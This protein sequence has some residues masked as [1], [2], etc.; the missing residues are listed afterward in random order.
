MFLLTTSDSIPKRRETRVSVPRKFGLWMV[1]PICV[2][3]FWWWMVAPSRVNPFGATTFTQ[4][5][6]SNPIRSLTQERWLGQKGVRLRSG[7]RQQLFSIFVFC[8]VGGRLTA[9][10]ASTP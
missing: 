5:M 1:A 6:V 9:A 8:F 10:V 4:S 2:Y 3:Q 7:S